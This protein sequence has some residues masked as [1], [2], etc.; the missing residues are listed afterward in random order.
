[1]QLKFTIN[2]HKQTFQWIF[3]NVLRQ[4]WYYGQRQI[5]DKNGPEQEKVQSSNVVHFTPGTDTA[6]E[7]LP[8]HRNKVKI[9]DQACNRGDPI[10]LFQALSQWGW[11]KKRV[12]DK[13]DLLKKNRGGRRKESL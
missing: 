6:V 3:K 9:S 8:D 11:S 12:Q 2:S 7:V 10:S 1:M 13:R 4:A 5:V